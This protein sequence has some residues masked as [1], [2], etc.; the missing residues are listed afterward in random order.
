VAVLDL[1][2]SAGQACY[3]GGE[4]TLRVTVPA[5][6]TTVSVGAPYAVGGSQ[7]CSNLGINALFPDL[8]PVQTTGWRV[9]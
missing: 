9:G 3:P 2:A 6:S 7:S 5:M 8:D 4:G 1:E